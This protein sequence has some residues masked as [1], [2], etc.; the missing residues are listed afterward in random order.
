M[1]TQRRLIW[2][3]RL[4]AAPFLVLGGWCL[5]APHQVEALC[6][7][8]EYQH[9]SVTSAIMIGCFGAQA[10]LCGLFISLSR[11]TR[12]A[13]LAYGLSLFLFFAFNYY[14]VFAEPVFSKWMALDFIANVF[15]LGLCVMGYR[16]SKNTPA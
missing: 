11:L 10:M 1:E 4:L 16:L 8:P 3:Q 7:R 12:R 13:F 14:F 5:I 15:M 2:I 6:F 9:L